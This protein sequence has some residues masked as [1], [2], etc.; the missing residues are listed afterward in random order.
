M[1]K[2]KEK[3]AL[4]RIITWLIAHFFR[5]SC[6]KILSLSLLHFTSTTQILRTSKTITVVK[7][8]YTLRS[9][10]SEDSSSIWSWRRM[11]K[12]VREH[13]FILFPSKHYY[14]LKLFYNNFTPSHFSVVRL[15]YY[16]FDLYSVFWFQT[17]I[18]MT[19]FLFFF[20]F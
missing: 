9:R 3:Q 14:Y 13:T 11:K 18:L 15:G 10:S 1:K 12:E 5:V 4:S 19:Y 7:K 20:W 6:V 16:V 2:W 17:L 8:C